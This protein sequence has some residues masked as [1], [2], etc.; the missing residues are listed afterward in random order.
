M[1]YFKKKKKEIVKDEYK[2]L[3]ESKYIIF[4]LFSNL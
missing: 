3:E 4:I 1:D 2:E